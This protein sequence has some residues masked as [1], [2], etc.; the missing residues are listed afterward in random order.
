MNNKSF[1]KNS[2]GSVEVIRSLEY[3]STF[4]FGVLS[5]SVFTPLSAP[6]PKR[7]P[8][9]FSKLNIISAAPHND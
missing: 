9:H 8:Q 7:A 4:L 3:S 1:L 5:G 2:R 6:A